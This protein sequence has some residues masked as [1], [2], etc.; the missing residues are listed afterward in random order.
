MEAILDPTKYESLIVGI[1]HNSSI[2]SL[3]FERLLGRELPI[4]VLY[5]V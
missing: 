2:Y 5:T 4:T 3:N 1:T